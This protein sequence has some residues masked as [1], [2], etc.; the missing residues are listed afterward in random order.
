MA[1]ERMMEETSQI[2]R[3]EKSLTD[4][5]YLDREPSGLFSALLPRRV[6]AG[7]QSRGLSRPP[8]GEGTGTGP[9]F[10]RL[11]DTGVP[12]LPP[13]PPLAK[14][15]RSSPLKL[16]PR[17]KRPITLF[18]SFVALDVG[19]RKL[20]DLPTNGPSWDDWDEES[21]NERSI[22]VSYLASWQLP[23]GKTACAGENLFPFLLFHWLRVEEVAAPHGRDLKSG[24]IECC[25]QEIL[26]TRSLAW[27]CFGGCRNIPSA[28][29]S[30]EM[31]TQS[32]F[33]VNLFG[34]KMSWTNRLQTTIKKYLKRRLAGLGEA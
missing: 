6:K 26:I 19:V 25:F 15:S 22:W 16:E 28:I 13:G 9:D 31:A 2:Y 33:F 11:A 14:F 4:P 24:L 27:G 18:I 32:Q 8:H 20:S 17:R 23:L 7:E 30:S 21:I 5:F 29:I 34:A 1:I 3:K 12:T 10:I